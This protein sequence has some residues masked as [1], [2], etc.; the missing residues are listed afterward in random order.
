MKKILSLCLLAPSLIFAQEIKVPAGF[1]ETEIA[2]NVGATRHLAV[3]KQ[4]DIYAKLSK[5]KDGK[6]IV[7]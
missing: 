7:L 3:S 5:L 1:Q 4:G 6:G 2:K